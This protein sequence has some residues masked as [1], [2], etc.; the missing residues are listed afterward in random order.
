MGAWERGSLPTD[1]LRAQCRFQA[2]RRRRQRG[3]RIPQNLWAVAVELVPAHGVSATA[4]ALGLDYYSLKRR[5]EEPAD[6]APP[7]SPAFIEMPSPV[8]KQALFEL[9]HGGGTIR[10]LQLMGYD[11]PDIESLTRCFWNAE[12]CSKSPRR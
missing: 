11:A 7:S 3:E 5:A 2:W 6:E 1:L 9:H 12:R 8:S 10:R 4:M